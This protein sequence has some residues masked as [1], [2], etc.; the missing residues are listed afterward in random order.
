MRLDRKIGR[1]VR[2]ARVLA[3]V[4][5]PSMNAAVTSEVRVS[6]VLLNHAVGIEEGSI[7]RH[8]A[9]HH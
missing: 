8:G 1:V 2:P 4:L 7:Q 6:H 3:C 9:L 5:L